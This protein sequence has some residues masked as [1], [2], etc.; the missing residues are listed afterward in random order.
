MNRPFWPWRSREAAPLAACLG[1]EACAPAGTHPSLAVEKEMGH[2][3][4]RRGR[5]PCSPSGTGGFT[6]WSNKRIERASQRRTGPERGPERGASSRRG[7]HLGD[8]QGRPANWAPAQ[9]HPPPH[10]QWPRQPDCSLPKARQALG[11][12]HRSGWATGSISTCLKPLA[13]TRQWRCDGQ[14]TRQRPTLL[15]RPWILA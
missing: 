13:A 14:L 1:H 10:W 15:P 9:G 11:P 8:R 12:Q 4:R 6:A 5:K 7:R 3:Q 2:R